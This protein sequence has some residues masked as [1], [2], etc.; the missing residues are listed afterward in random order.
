MSLAFLFLSDTLGTVS[1]WLMV[2]VT[3][4]TAFFLYKTLKSQKEVQHTQNELFKIE[5]IRFRE[6]I[7][8]LLKYSASVD[9]LKP[10]DESKKIL[11]VEV[12]NETDSM[13]LDISR[14]VSENEQTQQ[15]VVPTG[16]SDIRNH[17]IK[18]DSPMLFHFLIDSNAYASKYIN[19]ALK[20][21]DVAGTKYKQGVFC[22]CDNYG[23]EINPFLPEVI[24]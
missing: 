15:I 22:I 11:T 5:S 14:F 3:A 2:V 6:S 1:D 24:N 10:G 13:A 4:I 8:P 16:F 20:Y 19:F 18:G 21:Q 9:K 7:K 23:I 12:I 17:L